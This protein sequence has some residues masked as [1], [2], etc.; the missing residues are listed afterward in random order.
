[1]HLLS[2]LTLAT[3]THALVLDTRQQ[4]S[5]GSCA[6]G[7]HVIAAGGGNSNDPAAIG[8]LGSLARLIVSKIPGSDFVSLP[9]DKTEIAPQK[10]TPTAIPNGV[11]VDSPY[12]GCVAY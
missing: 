5:P 1:M 6:S 3:A 7:V 9:Y 4:T 2:A 10:L 8:L 11:S 12:L